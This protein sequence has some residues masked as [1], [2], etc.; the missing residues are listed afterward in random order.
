VAQEQLADAEVE[1][2]ESVAAGDDHDEIERRRDVDELAADAAGGEHRSR[3]RSSS[4]P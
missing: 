4:V 1:A 3:G 2:I